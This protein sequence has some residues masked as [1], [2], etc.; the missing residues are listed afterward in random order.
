[1]ELKT[2]IKIIIVDDHP[3][4]LEGLKA[5]L[6]NK[7]A[8]DIVNSFKNGKEAIDYVKNNK[9]D[10]VLLDINLQDINGVDVCKKLIEH[11]SKTKVIGLSTYSDA[12]IINQ[13]IGN[14]ASGYLLKNVPEK[15]LINAIKKVHKGDSYFDK[16]VAA[17]LSNP[18]FENPIDTPRITRREKEILELISEGITTSKIAESLFISPL[19]VET[20][21]ANLLKKMNVTNVA[22][23]IKVAIEKKII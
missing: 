2:N 17:I 3:M 7:I 18:V 23:L 11:R 5:L 16:E 8:I 20:H 21:R 19:T 9:I 4:V 22:Q 1:M 14:G 10:V 15:E 13:M 12:S 6:S